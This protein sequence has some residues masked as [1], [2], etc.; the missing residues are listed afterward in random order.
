LQDTEDQTV[1]VGVRT[2]N[3]L[4][5]IDG[6]TQA[7]RETN[8]ITLA[9]EGNYEIVVYGWVTQ[10]QNFLEIVPEYYIPPDRFTDAIEITGTQRFGAPIRLRGITDGA[11]RYETAEALRARAEALAY[12][13]RGTSYYITRDYEKAIELFTRAT[14]VEGWEES[15]GREVLDLLL[16]NAHWQI[17]RRALSNCEREILLDELDQA[18]V[19]YDQAIAAVDQP[20][21]QPNYARAY[22]GRAEVLQMR[23]PWI[24]PDE[25]SPCEPQEG[26]FDLLLQAQDASNAAIQSSD[27]IGLPSIL[28]TQIYLT[29]LR[30]TSSLWYYTPVD[31]PAWED[32]ANSIESTATAILRFY[33][34]EEDSIL[35]A[36][37]AFEALNLR[38]SM[39]I[40]SVSLRDIENV[41][42]CDE[43]GLA[44]FQ[45]SVEIP[46]MPPHRLVFAYD[47]IG[48]CAELSGDVDAAV[49]AY[50][51]ARDLAEN[52]F[53][54]EL[55]QG[56]IDGLQTLESSGD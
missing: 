36:P 19:F 5:R 35:I 30:V 55:Y 6:T 56:L 1:T 20:G 45:S 14:Q 11:V 52:D 46:D 23:A 21:G 2:A 47:V 33:E 15:E 51:R 32:L 27:F 40:D 49:E 38:G 43:D 54:R 53:D 37:L 16:G 12:V 34:E 18:E 17:A 9:K 13:I 28:Q 3:L 48:Q 4:E 50:E 7:E 31:D 22:A 44:D 8:A 25:E 10:R 26:D 42:T 41:T 39:R 29:K 24:T